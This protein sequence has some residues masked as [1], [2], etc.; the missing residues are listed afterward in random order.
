MRTWRYFWPGGWGVVA[1]KPFL[2]FVHFADRKVA[3][4]WSLES[5]TLR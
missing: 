1:K 3:M 5:R 4:M 2:F